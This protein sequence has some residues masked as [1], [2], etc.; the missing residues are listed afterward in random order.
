MRGDG[1]AWGCSLCLDRDGIRLRSKR[2]RGREYR[3]SGAMAC[4]RSR[5][6]RTMWSPADIV[7]AAAAGLARAAQAMDLDLEQEKEQDLGRVM[8]QKKDQALEEMIYLNMNMFI[9]I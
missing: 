1:S 6:A 4:V 3:V 8:D 2:S 7:D 9:I 5:S